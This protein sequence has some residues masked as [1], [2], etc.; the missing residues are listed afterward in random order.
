MGRALKGPDQGTRVAR[1]AVDHGRPVEERRRSLVGVVAGEH[2]D[3]VALVEAAARDRGAKQPRPA[4][5]GDG[6]RWVMT[7]TEPPTQ[8]SGRRTEVLRHEGRGYFGSRAVRWNTLRMVRIDR[9]DP[10]SWRR[11]AKVRL[12]A[13][14]DEPDAFGSSAEAEREHDASTWRWIASRGPWWLA[15]KDDVD[16]GMV[17]CGLRDAD[18]STRWVYSMWVDAS[19][20]GLGVARSLLD[21]AAT[22]AIEDGATRLG[23]DVTDRVPRAR[24]FYERC[25]FVATGVV[26]PLPRDPTIELSEMT[27]DLA[28]WAAAS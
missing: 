21:A 28:S 22:W 12:T 26:I 10:S 16:V 3:A 2:R 11:L 18:D 1:V 15:V 6:Q 5:H 8:A 14:E 23:L 19:C 17:S 13:L 27:A 20:R 24:R 9:L 7:P 4:E 25:G